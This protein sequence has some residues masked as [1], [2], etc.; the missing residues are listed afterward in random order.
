MEKTNQ[1]KTQSKAERSKSWLKA[2][3]VAG[4]VARVCAAAYDAAMAR[5]GFSGRSSGEDTSIGSSL[6]ESESP[7]IMACMTSRVTVVTTLV[8]SLTMT[9]GPDS[10]RRC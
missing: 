6:S 7:T 9:R 1:G 3:A 10:T 8:V 5:M 4:A 2:E